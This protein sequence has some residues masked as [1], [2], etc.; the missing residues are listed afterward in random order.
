MG[1]SKPVKPQPRPNLPVKDWHAVLTIALLVAFFFRDI[2]L[3][4]AFFWEDFI[5]QYYPFRN[6]A[7]V[8]MN[9]GQLPLW[10]PFTFNGMPFQADIQTAVFYL[11]N[12][13]LTLFVSSG[14]LPFYWLE[15]VIVLHYVIAGVCM[16]YLSKDLGVQR[17]F[18]LFG[19]VVYALSGFM[20][21]QV[22]HETFVCQ[23][24]WLPLVVLL[25][26][27]S[28]LRLSAGYMIGAALVLGHA[29]LAGSPQFTLYVFMLL[30][31][32]FCFEFLGAMK[33]A[34]AKSALRMIPLGAGMIVLSLALTAV[35]LLPTRELASLSARA[36]ISFAQSAE[37]SLSWA[38]LLTFLAPKFFGTSGA[39]GSTFWLS[40]LYWQYWETAM[41]IGA[42]GLMAVCAAMALFRKER[43]VR[44]LTGIALF[45]LLYALGDNFFLH[46]FFFNLVPGFDK[47]RV[48]GRMVF[49]FTFAAGVLSAFGLQHL[50]ELELS[51]PARLQKKILWI[52]AAAIIL[53][54]IGVSGTFERGRNAQELA[55]VHSVAMSGVTSAVVILV[56]LTGIMLLACRRA[57]SWLAALGALFALQCVDINIFAF[58]QNNGETNPDEYYSRSS[59]II[60]LLK[61]EGKQEYFRINSRLG[62]AMLL[63]RNLGMVD[64]VFMMEG[65][66]PLALQ[67]IFPA[68][69]DWDQTC[70]LLNAKYRIKLNEQDKTAGMIRSTTYLPRAYMVYRA[71]VLPA[72]SD[73]KSFMTGP[74]FDPSRIV[75]LEEEPAG[76]PADTAYGAGWSA[77]IT[78][79]GL[80]EIIL[81]VN[82][83]KDG[84]L[85]LSEI[86]YPGWQATIDGGKAPIYRA[87]WNLRA[88]PVKSGAHRVEVR[89]EPRSYHDGLLV[90]S[91]ALCLS[92]GGLALS[93]IAQRRKRARSE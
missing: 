69:R 39:T 59:N 53:W 43:Y 29:V 52:G 60:D 62:Q 67:R 45:G 9:N 50:F 76:L 85:V 42:A 49:Y 17:V 66:T 92:A 83:P 35:Q 93:F 10:N 28:L 14:R 77:A 65:Y 71:K 41:Y 23:V 2:L 30:F 5:Y 46:S 87:D 55:Q 33:S 88:I 1:S 73:V 84:L 54:L 86:F 6:F 79:Y 56:I 21:M 34:G 22:I 36:E 64:R 40:G 72:E 19:G 44:F 32:Y 90:T 38:Q 68:A 8:S 31:L 75:V 20:I 80:D 51:Q 89:F 74:E 63:D 11:P 57:I 48:P 26:R 25:F 27:R 47:F 82:S 4:K 91:S 13:L 18:A 3:Q 15:V 81:S 16:Y 70:D 78:S 58:D 61:E 37:G 7:A 12:L 24:A